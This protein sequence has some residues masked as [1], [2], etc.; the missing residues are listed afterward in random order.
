MNQKITIGKLIEEIKKIS[1][2]E[3]DEYVPT[4]DHY[5]P[6]RY[7]K[8]YLLM[9]YAVGYDEGRHSIGKSNAQPVKQIKNGD[10]VRIWDSHFS[11]SKAF[12]IHHASID[13]A[14][15]KHSVCCGFEWEG[16][17]KE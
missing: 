7:L 12:N 10:V 11:A 4:L 13:K 17:K 1:I 16:I 5:M 3:S 9:A 15:R 2:P 14:V 6:L 8:Q